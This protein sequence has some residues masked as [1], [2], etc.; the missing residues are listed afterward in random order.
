MSTGTR[1]AKQDA[2]LRPVPFEGLEILGDAEVGLC[3]D[4]VCDIPDAVLAT[5]QTSTDDR[6]GA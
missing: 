1:A 4:G 5:E 2:P 6:P 3:V